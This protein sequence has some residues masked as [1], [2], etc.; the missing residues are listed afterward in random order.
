M[1][2]RLWIVRL[3]TE[4]VQSGGDTVVGYVGKWYNLVQGFNA[5]KGN[6]S[7]RFKVLVSVWIT[8]TNTIA[9][10]S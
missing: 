1:S 7:F 9:N 4:V 3:V 5:Q 8:K 2:G 6:E 10:R